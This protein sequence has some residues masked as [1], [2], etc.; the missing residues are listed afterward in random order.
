MQQSLIVVL[1]KLYL[2]K[3]GLTANWIY[4]QRMKSLISSYLIS[5]NTESQSIQVWF[6]DQ[7]S[8]PLEIQDSVNI[9]L[10]IG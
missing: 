1:A 2:V 9:T 4:Y 5:T 7:N 6:T 3:S 8:R 10:F